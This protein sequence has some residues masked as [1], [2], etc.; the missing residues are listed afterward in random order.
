MLIPD[1]C[2]PVL[3]CTT[4]RRPFKFDKQSHDVLCLT[5]PSWPTLLCNL[6]RSYHDR[7]A[8]AA[9]A[10]ICLTNSR[11]RRV[12]YSNDAI[13]NGQTREGERERT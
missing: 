8:A 11:S 10:I 7:N 12:F 13:I 5:L 2:R 6:Q 1:L 3:I 9:A 4:I